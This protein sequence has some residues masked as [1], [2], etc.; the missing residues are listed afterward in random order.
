MSSGHEKNAQ[1]LA[2]WSSSLEQRFALPD[3]EGLPQLDLYMDQI[4]I[5][6]T[7]YLAPI[8]RGQEDKA[9]TASIIN[10]YVRMKIVP[11]PVKKKYS[12]VHI[13]FLVVICTLKQSLTISSIQRMLPQDRSE[14]AVRDFYNGFV[15]QYRATI[16]ALRTGLTGNRLLLENGSVFGTASAI[17]AVLA[18]DLTEFLLW[19]DG[20]DSEYG[21]YDG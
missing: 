17:F 6:L 1:R 7:Q 3:W 10:N 8:S 16:S 15:Q 20:E 18:K 4:I 19:G 14:E 13:A 11:P 12:R 21:E 5:L 2:A 9:I